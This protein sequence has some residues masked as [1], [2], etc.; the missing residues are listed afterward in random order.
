MGFRLIER[1][2]M[3]KAKGVMLGLALIPVGYMRLKL[4]IFPDIITM[5]IKSATNFSSIA[6][7]G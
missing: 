7:I 6:V 3:M 2:S 5:Q 4:S 1:D